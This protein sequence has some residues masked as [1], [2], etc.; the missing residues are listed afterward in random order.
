MLG[1]AGRALPTGRPWVLGRGVVWATQVVFAHGQAVGP[2]TC[3]D[4]VAVPHWGRL[5]ALAAQLSSAATTVRSGLQITAVTA[6]MT[7]AT[8]A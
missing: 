4:Q 7:T 2:G 8:K 5:G 6:M 3:W 1:G